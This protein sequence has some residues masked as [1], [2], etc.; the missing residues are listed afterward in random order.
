[1]KSQSCEL[2]RSRTTYLPL[3]PPDDTGSDEDVAAP[4]SVPY[5]PTGSERDIWSDPDQSDSGSELEFDGTDETTN[6]EL[7]RHHHADFLIRETKAPYL[8]ART[9]ASLDHVTRGRIAWNVVTSY[10]TSAAK[11]L[12]KEDVLPSEERYKI[13]HEYMDLVYS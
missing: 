12:G 4:P 13:A 11:V 1:M 8:L 5:G 9:W 10:S 2:R 3:P 6:A 7:A